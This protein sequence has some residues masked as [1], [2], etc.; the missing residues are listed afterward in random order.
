M[1]FSSLE[2]LYLFLPLC[3]LIYFL[4]PAKAKN[5]VLLAASLVF[6]ALPEPA[7]LPLL[8]TVSLLSFAVG[9]AVSRAVRLGRTRRAKV[10]VALAVFINIG[11]LFA[12]KYL[13]P[14]LSL[15]GAETTGI[16]LPTGI[17][18][19]T[20]QALSYVID[21]RREQAREQKSFSKFLLYVSLFPQLIAGPIVRYSQIDGYL[22]SRTHSTS[23][24]ADGLRLFLVGLSKKVLLADVAGEEWERLILLSK[25]VPTSLGSALALLFF[26]FRIYFDF[27]GYSDMARGLG[28]IFGFELPVNFKYPYAA[29]SVSDFWRRWHVTLSAYFR[30]YVYFSLGGSRHGRARTYLSLFAVWSLTGLWHGASLNFLIWG[31]YFFALLCLEKGALKNLL[32]RLPSTM[33]RFCTLTAVFFGW[34][35]FCCDGETLTLSEGVSMLKSLLGVGVPLTSADSLFELLRSLPMI[36]IMAIGSTPLPRRA[37]FSLCRS[38][39]RLSHPLV[40]LISVTSFFICTSFIAGGSYLPFLYFK[41]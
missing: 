31:L 2:F 7:F 14:L 8:V 25:S 9:R 17:S 40:A 27:S 18:F 28:K 30:E 22:D 20:F 36:F 12:F 24:A 35:I 13:D 1:L 23:L 29:Q 6:Y 3:V 32:P 41:F 39:K 26:S 16:A 34:L 15:I 4:A 37:F 11:A 33:R 21:V 10:V 19:Y 38:L 5:G